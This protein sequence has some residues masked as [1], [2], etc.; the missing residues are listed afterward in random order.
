MFP[1][2][3]NLAIKWLTAW[4]IPRWY[5]LATGQAGLLKTTWIDMATGKMEQALSALILTG[6]IPGRIYSL[7]AGMVLV[8]NGG[9]I[10]FLDATGMLKRETKRGR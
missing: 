8:Y 3:M 4:S 5:T 2:D 7:E 10:H 1:P 6:R 9:R